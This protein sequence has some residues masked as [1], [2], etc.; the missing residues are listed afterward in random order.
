[1]DPHLPPTAYATFLQNHDQIGNRALGERLSHI[2]KNP[3]ALRAA[4]AV[5]LLAPCPPMLFMGEEWNAPEPFPYFCDF[6]SDLAAK[7]REGRK[8]EFTR[9]DRFRDPKNAELIPDPTSPATVE[10]ARLDWSRLTLSRHADWLDLYRRLLAI[11]QR[12]I[13][14]LIPDIRFASC[15]K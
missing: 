12:D 13:V 8:K 6:E 9:F 3:D 7:V 11:R 5:L 1:F 10:S 14:T 4:V 2:V 15:S